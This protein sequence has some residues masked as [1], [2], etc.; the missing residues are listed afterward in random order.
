VNAVGTETPL[1]Q[2]LDEARR[3]ASAALEQDVPIR[4]VGG[5][6]VR[7][8]VDETFHPG[9]SRAYKDIDFVTLKGRSKLVSRFLEEMGYEPQHQFNAMNG[10]ERLLFHDLGNER[11][12]DV[13]VGAFRM[14]HEIPITDRIILDPM[15]LPLAELLLTK[16][17]IVK[18]NEKDLRDVVAIL[19]HHEIADHD[20]DTINA[21]RVAELCANDWGLWRTCK[22]NVERVRDGV[23]HYDMA[24]DERA[25]VD[26]RLDR[27]WERIDAEPKSRGWRMRDRIGDRKRWYDEPEEVDA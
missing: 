9:L 11:Q 13:F 16:L 21:A 15:T 25:T 26:E 24:Q 2:I 5:L 17:Q 8:R 23:A 22:M 4:L 19:H 14:C 18:L 7:I 6:A 10:H 12:L 20:G 1:P 27:L 3:L